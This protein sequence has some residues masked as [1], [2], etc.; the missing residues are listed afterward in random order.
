[1]SKT[2]V[3]NTKNSLNHNFLVHFYLNDALEIISLTLYVVNSSFYNDEY[4]L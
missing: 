2:N 3:T 1:M 4:V